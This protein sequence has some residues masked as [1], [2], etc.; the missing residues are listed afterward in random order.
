MAK[1]SVL[2]IDRVIDK[3]ISGQIDQK[4][5]QWLIPAKKL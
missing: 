3:E 1:R 5:N 4:N 2:I